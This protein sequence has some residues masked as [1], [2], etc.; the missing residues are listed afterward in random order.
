MKKERNG[1]LTRRQRRI[2][3]FRRMCDALWVVVGAIGPGHVVD[4]ND[5]END[6]PYFGLAMEAESLA[7]RTE[8]IIEQLEREERRKEK[9]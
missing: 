2:L 5:P 8:G 6:G 1:E 4:D 9:S 7:M 3:V